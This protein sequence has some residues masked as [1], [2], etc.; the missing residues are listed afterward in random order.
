MLSI[1]KIKI[2]FAL[3]LA[4]GIGLNACKAKNEEV[5][6]GN[7]TNTLE[8]PSTYSFESRFES[9]VS[10]VDYTGQVVRNLLVQDIKH[11]I[12]DAATAATPPV[13]L[14]SQVLQLYNH[15]DTDNL[16]TV[17]KNKH[18]ASFT[19][20][21]YA[22]IATGKN[23][24]GKIS[25]AT[26][27]GY[28]QTADAL[29]KGWLDKIDANVQAGKTGKDIYIDATTKVDYNQLINKVLLGALTYSQGAGHYLNR[30]GEENN[31]EPRQKEGK[32]ADPFTVMEH[33]FDEGFGYFGAARDYAAYSD[34]AL[35]AKN[36]LTFYKDANGDSKVDFH[37]EYNFG[38]SRNAG[39]RDRGGAK[40]TNFT[41][42]AFDAFLAGRTA[43]YNKADFATV[44]EPEIKK[45][46]QTW[47]KVIAATIIHYINE[48]LNDMTAVGT[49]NENIPNLAKHWSE[50]KGFL[51][52][53]QYGSAKYKLMT[54]AI[55]QD[56]QTKVGTAP[57]VANDA[58]YKT[59]LEEVRTSLKNTYSFDDSSVITW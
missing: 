47:E 7:S 57:V 45:A 48:T 38:F 17:T 14:K 24:P 30:V 50:M 19:E 12:D 52:A 26:V 33:V 1:Q 31:T 40:N 20:T 43:I 5:T 39:K 11:L 53:L 37:S 44:I 46:A 54:D 23:I 9:G 3:L 36:G 49:T 13:N 32:S 55:L 41:K 6:P 28:N 2:Q 22:K 10:S 29:V 15:L 4:A 27:I 59:K 42:E 51:V 34:D 25:D 35:A 16:E 21:F 56:L 18:N 8:V 58:T